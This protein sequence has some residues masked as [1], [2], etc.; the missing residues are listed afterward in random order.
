M[1]FSAFLFFSIT[2]AYGQTEDVHP[3]KILGPSIIYAET[4]TDSAVVDYGPIA[5]DSEERD[6]VEVICDPPSGSTFFIG[7][8]SVTC[9]ATDTSGNQAE[10]FIFTVN[11]TY[12]APPEPEDS[13][14][15]NSENTS[16]SS[17]SS[18]GTSIA[19]KY[20]APEDEPV[21]EESEPESEPVESTMNLI[22][23]PVS[24]PDWI[25]NNASW[26][27]EDQID[28]ETF[29]SGIEFLISD[30]V[31]KIPETESGVA[32]SDIAI[33]DWVKNNAQ[34]WSQGLID[35]E[36]F[37]SSLQFLI[38]EGVLTI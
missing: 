33:P 29:A 21:K 20:F 27:A 38:T 6:L 1:L 22:A 14:E 26:W 9:S 8:T 23:P 11:V 31:I 16:T 17:Q 10:D 35:D 5:I 34:W 7:E 37:A 13:E 19:E 4:S 2:T 25:K 30:Q 36:T 28:D 15:N 3:P 18:A 12:V 24:I 32:E